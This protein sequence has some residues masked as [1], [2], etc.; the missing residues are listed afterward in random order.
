MVTLGS[1]PAS[2]LF[3]CNGA[4]YTNPCGTTPTTVT[5][6]GGGVSI[7]NSSV[8]TLSSAGAYRIVATIS[9]G[10]TTVI[11]YFNVA[12]SSGTL[13]SAAFGN[14]S[15]LTRFAYAYNITCY[16]YGVSA[17]TTLTFSCDNTSFSAGPWVLEVT[18]I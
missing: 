9:P 16:V 12:T 5:T 3:I 11:Y 2:G 10:D 6:L 14:S 17:N 13:T 7:N 4:V 15:K 18:Q 1:S 8:V